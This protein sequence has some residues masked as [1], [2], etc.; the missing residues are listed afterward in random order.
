MMNDVKMG[1]TKKEYHAEFQKNYFRST[2]LQ[3]QKE[4]TEN[5]E[6]MYYYYL[7]MQR[8]LPRFR[9]LEW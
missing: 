2:E 3:E 5:Q 4:T 6:I 7:L 9:L 1:L 8:R